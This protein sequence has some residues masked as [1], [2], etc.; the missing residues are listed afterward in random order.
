MARNSRKARKNRSEQQ[1]TRSNNQGQETSDRKAKT[2]DVTINLVADDFGVGAKSTRA[3]ISIMKFG[4]LIPAMWFLT[5]PHPR[6]GA[7]QIITAASN[8]HIDYFMCP[9]RF[10]KHHHHPSAAACL[11]PFDEDP[12]LLKVPNVIFFDTVAMSHWHNMPFS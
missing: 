6:K 1:Q 4:A 8:L 11:V 2:V 7:L 3:L 9:I 12:R 5:L 10:F